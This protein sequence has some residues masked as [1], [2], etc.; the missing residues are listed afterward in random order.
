M[1]PLVSILIPA[2]NKEKWIA[3]TIRSV[4][5]QTWEPKE[6]IVVD[7]GSTDRTVDIARQFDPKLVRV[8]MQSNEGASSA[9]NKALSLSSGSYI[10]WLDA[11]DL[12]A[13]DKIARQMKVAQGQCT[14]RTLLSS[15][16]GRFFYRSS[17]ARFVASTLWCDLQP[18]D[19]LL[20]KMGQKV[21]MPI[22][23][24]LVSR[25]LTE[26]VGPWDASISLDDDGEYFSR[27]V[28]ASD[29]IRF[30]PEAK[31]FYRSVGISSLS[32][33][34]YSKRSLDGFWRSMGLHIGR[35]R[36][37][38]DTMTARGACLRYLQSNVID[39]YPRRPDI[40]A[41]MQEIAAELGEQLKLPQLSWKYRWI[42]A[43]FGWGC[44][45]RAQMFFP[46]IKWS[47]VRYWD[48]TLFNLERR[49]FRENPG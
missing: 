39:F 2:Y 22:S 7:D 44:A 24:W 9:R 34:V 25:E 3:E 27:A 5:A 15:S 18:V 40:V 14:S 21:F 35:L 49:G 41:E 13:P 10:Q 45:K 30:V 8:V 42:K 4:L 43:L 32:R 20:R 29:G 16:W 11:D 37:L 26:S 48:E 36:S 47:L 46:D 28:V 12:L 23:C 17:H 1:K 19:F 31:V 38:D 33:D 6:I